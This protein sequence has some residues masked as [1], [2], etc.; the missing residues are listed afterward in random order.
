MP[1]TS[2]AIQ[3]QIAALA[4]DLNKQI[5][6]QNQFSKT[7]V[8]GIQGAYKNLDKELRT[9]LADIKGNVSSG[10][11]GVVGAY[12][13][14]DQNINN[15]QATLEEL[16]QGNQLANSGPLAEIQRIAA[17][18][19]LSRADSLASFDML[20]LG[21]TNA[22]QMAIGDAAREGTRQQG[23]LRS[24]IG[25]EIGEL[26]RNALKERSALEVQYAQVLAE[27]KY[28]A[29]QMA[30]ERARLASENAAR[31]SA[32]RQAD[33]PAYKGR[34]GL[35]QWAAAN[36]IPPDQLNAMLGAI[37]KAGVTGDMSAAY[38]E[39]NRLAAKSG[40]AKNRADLAGW[41]PLVKKSIE[42]NLPK[43]K[44][45]NLDMLNTGLDIY[46]GNYATYQ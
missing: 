1:S 27:E 3:Q 12:D 15:A 18:Q 44:S 25:A 42:K 46:F 33:A 38:A 8:A 2:E 11:T 9:N 37:N 21:H 5:A 17:E 6:I 36:N 45:Y 22:G 40:K 43:N 24:Q 28:R 31:A 7:G 19:G 4:A 13:T 16:L 41:N 14:A 32:A 35:M 29:E 23:D 26:Q 30:L 39:I 10:R 34:E 20:G